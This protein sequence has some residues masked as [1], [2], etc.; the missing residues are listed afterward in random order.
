MG[1]Q[2]VG[3][4]I[5]FR[6]P[7]ALDG[8]LRQRAQAWEASVGRYVRTLVIT[9]LA[10]DGTL[11]P[12]SV[13]GAL[14]AALVAVGDMK[15]DPDGQELAAQYLEPLVE[16]SS[17]PPKAEVEPE[18]SEIASLG[19]SKTRPPSR[20]QRELAHALDPQAVSAPVEAIE[21][22]M[23]TPSG[24]SA[25]NRPCEHRNKRV[26]GGGLAFCPDC[27]LRRQADGRWA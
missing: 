8:V 24:K 25:R 18:I 10:D 14:F 6:L 11:E 5:S 3:P 13:P 7:L 26:L 21:P 22:A 12:V 15:D 19:G 23:D 9:A 17:E 20:E 16:A 27:Q 1:T 2:T 4:V